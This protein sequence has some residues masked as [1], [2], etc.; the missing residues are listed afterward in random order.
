MAG[1][2][3]MPRAAMQVSG[4]VAS[5]WR[6][7]SWTPVAASSAYNPPLRAPTYTR[8]PDTIGVASR[9]GRGAPEMIGGAHC[10][11]RRGAPVDGVKARRPA[12]RRMLWSRP[13]TAATNPTPHQTP[14]TKAP[15]A[16]KRAP[17]R[18]PHIAL[19]QREQSPCATISRPSNSFGRGPAVTVS[20]GYADGGAGVR[21]TSTLG[22]G[23][24]RRRT[25][26][27]T[28]SPVCEFRRVDRQADRLARPWLAECDGRQS[29]DSY[30][31]SIPAGGLPTCFSGQ[32]QNGHPP[33]PDS[34][35][36]RSPRRLR[37]YRHRH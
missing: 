23:A 33:P 9:S 21:G 10:Q 31:R 22:P 17:P 29:S 7:H 2:P 36:N 5:S 27:P 25:P 1:V 14:P 4:W 26:R 28:P 13:N 11:A 15:T 32:V 20:K 12:N 6:C 8:P 30:L 18:L 24:R 16:P 19:P 3:V 34:D 37:A 35:G